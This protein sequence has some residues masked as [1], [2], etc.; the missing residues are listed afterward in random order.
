MDAASESIRDRLV[1]ALP[2]ALKERDTLAVDA[3]RSALAA[4][5]NAA[6]V[7]EAPTVTADALG[8]DTATGSAPLA[9]VPATPSPTSYHV[10]GAT[11][12]V[13][14]TEVPRRE[15]TESDLLAIVVAEAAERE[16]EAATY[17]DLGQ[18]DAADRLVAQAAY[19]R[20]FTV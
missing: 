19:L 2:Q 3:L 11:A 20:E 1:A 5:E 16:T 7:A 14:A 12:G 15:L 10:A 9:D 17:R 8:H 4:I 13:G 18:A 6:A